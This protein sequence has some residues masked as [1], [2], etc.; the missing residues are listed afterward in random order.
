MLWTTRHGGRLG[1]TRTAPGDAEQVAWLLLLF[2]L[3]H[4]MAMMMLESLDWEQLTYAAPGLVPLAP[5]LAL[6]L[7]PIVGPSTAGRGVAFAR[8]AW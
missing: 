2:A 5:L 3:P 8:W 6:G 4:N 7:E 1:R